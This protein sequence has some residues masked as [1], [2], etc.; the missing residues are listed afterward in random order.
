MKIQLYEIWQA[1]RHT[2]LNRQ[3]LAICL[4]LG[5][6]SKLLLFQITFKSEGFYS[7]LEMSFDFI[8]ENL[9]ACVFMKNRDMMN[10]LT[11]VR[12][13]PRTGSCPQLC[14]YNFGLTC[15]LENV[16]SIKSLYHPAAIIVSNDFPA[17]KRHGTAHKMI[18]AYASSAIARLLSKTSIVFPPPDTFWETGWR[19]KV[20]RSPEPSIP[21]C[22]SPVLRHISKEWTNAAFFLKVPFQ[23]WNLLCQNVSLNFPI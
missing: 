15:E 23:S 3:D 13:K 21:C 16:E 10:A 7:N 17:H 8:F 1:W 12:T 4:I 18:Q 6:V 2:H 19:F 22:Y 11:W 14:Y 9:Y 20:V 5:K